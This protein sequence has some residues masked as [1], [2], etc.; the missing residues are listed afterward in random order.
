MKKLFCSML[1]LMMLLGCILPFAASAATEP[2]FAYELTVDGKEAVEVRKGD[3]ITVVVT[4]NRTDAKDAYTMYGM[5]AELRYD[6]DFFELVT[7]GAIL[8]KDIRSTDISVGGGYREFYMNYVNA[9]NGGAYDTE[10]W[11]E[12][13]LIGSFQLRVIA[14]TGT[15]KITNEDYLVSSQDGRTAYACTSNELNITVT[16]NCKVTFESNGGSAVES[17]TVE[18]GNTV[19]EPAKP[20]KKDFVFAGWYKDAALTKAWDFDTDKV[21]GPMTLYA[22][23]VEVTDDPVIPPTGDDM[24]QMIWIS[25]LA[26]MLAIT[27]LMILVV[28]R[29]RRSDAQ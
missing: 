10:T 19:T 18:E 24:G 8:S 5:Q 16:K 29:R 1:T 12:S 23:W 22:K 2:T 15:T 9:V 21:S 14:T 13:K 4:L 28:L 25:A 20:T 17:Q 3:I 27:A 7:D 6:T 26:S 11:G